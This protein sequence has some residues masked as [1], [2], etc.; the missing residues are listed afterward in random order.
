MYKIDSQLNLFFSFFKGFE[1]FVFRV[2]GTEVSFTF[3]FLTLFGVLQQLE[4][5][6]ENFLLLKKYKNQSSSGGFMFN[7]LY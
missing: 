5:I 1:H 7:Y 4:T 6:S 3:T 2:C